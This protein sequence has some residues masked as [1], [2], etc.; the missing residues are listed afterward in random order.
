MEVHESTVLTSEFDGK[1]YYFCS[2]GWQN[3]KKW[4]NT[5]HAI[6]FPEM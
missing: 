2:E 3:T 6:K 1:L 4:R 5:I